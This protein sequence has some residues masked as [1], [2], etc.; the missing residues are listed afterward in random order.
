MK[1]LARIAYGFF[2]QMHPLEFRIE[3][4]DEMLWIFDEQMMG[5]NR[6]TARVVLCAQLLLDVLRSAFLQHILRE[7]PQPAA[8][9]P[10]FGQMASSGGVVIQTGFILFC[11]LFN[12]FC[13]A[14][15]LRMVM[16]SL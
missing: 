14:L 4:A 6:Q 10:Y 11:S 5:A 8:V 15:G 9:G 2:V 3:F 13:I 1:S 12:I 7:K 16:S